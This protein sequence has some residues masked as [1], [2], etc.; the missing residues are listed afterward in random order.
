[1]ALEAVGHR[2]QQARA[3]PARISSMSRVAAP[4]R[5]PH[6]VAVDL[7]RRH[8]HSLGPRRDA[9]AGRH[10]RGG[11]VAEMRLSSHTNSTGSW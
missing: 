7:E 2:V 6:V 11:V 5:P 3:L 9:G 1:M 10:R 4:R 8:G